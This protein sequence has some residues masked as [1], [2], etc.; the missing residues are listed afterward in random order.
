MFGVGI[1]IL[2]VPRLKALTSRR[3]SARLAARIL[4]PPEHTLYDGLSNSDARL[5]F[6]AVRW[7]LKEAAYKAAYPSKRLTWKELA[8]G[9][10]DAL[11]A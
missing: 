3:G 10:S 2:H 8:Y 1:D 7:A 9:P 11:E 6:L 4:S 5:R